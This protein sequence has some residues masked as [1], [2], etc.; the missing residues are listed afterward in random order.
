MNAFTL[1]AVLFV[2]PG[3]GV[4]RGNARSSPICIALPL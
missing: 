2:T 4:T 1:M 3:Q